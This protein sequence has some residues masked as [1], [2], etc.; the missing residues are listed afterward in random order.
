MTEATT[1]VQTVGGEQAM[2]EEEI[3]ELCLDWVKEHYGEELAREYQPYSL[4]ISMWN[5]PALNQALQALMQELRI[6]FGPDERFGTVEYSEAR[7]KLKLSHD[8]TPIPEVFLQA[9][10][11]AYEKR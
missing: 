8:R 11:E 5:V 1:V 10:T 2:K 6:V 4:L 3:D 9:F 7:R